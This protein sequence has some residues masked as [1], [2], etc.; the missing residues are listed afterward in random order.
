[1][2]KGRTLMR[3]GTGNCQIKFADELFPTEGFDGIH[4][5][6][7]ASIVVIDDIEKVV[8]VSLEIVMLWDEFLAKCK[9]AVAEAVDVPVE[10]V[11]IHVT[12]A[13]AT[14]H[15]PGGPMI[16][17]GGNEVELSQ[18]EQ[19]KRSAEMEKRGLYEECIFNALMETAK[20]ANELK[21]ASV[22]LGVGKADLIQGRD[23]RTPEGWWIGTDGDG[24]SNQEM[25]IISFKDNS[26]N[27]MASIISYGM[28]P[29]VIDNSELDKGTR[30]V[31]ADAPGLCCRLLEKKYN[32]PMLYFTA[33]AGDRIPAKTAWYDKV[34][35]DGKIETVDIGVDFG[36]KAAAEIG[37]KMAN[38]A[39]DI[40][41]NSKLQES[42]A[43][44]HKATS[45]SWP[46]KGRIPMHPYT[47]LDFETDGKKD[48]PV[49]VIKIGDMALIGGKPEINTVTE[50]E[51]KERSTASVTLYMSMV[52]GGM[53]Y[54]P[55]QQGYDELRWE[56]L[57]SMLMPG[58]A[59]KFVEEAVKLI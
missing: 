30:K 44:S 16:G 57:A 9:S 17:L 5:N 58:A 2:R 19:E 27:I 49:E 24:D 26:G 37:E 41:E 31:S 4:D 53:K 33:A 23:I 55:N 25:T 45:F 8:L 51:L 13:I 34:G 40:I 11:W 1:M 59:E 46:T 43:V 39:S 38:I 6:P 22:F 3:I 29:C 15:A 28:K 32:A 48:V 10:K 50:M 20:K 56:A 21:E 18:G 14:P 42:T 36:I 47:S 35:N 54:M 7:M 52:N 12:H